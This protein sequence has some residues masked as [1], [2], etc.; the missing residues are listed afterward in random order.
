MNNLMGNGIDLL[1]I[2]FFAGC[3]LTAAIG[4]PLL[5]FR[6]IS[7]CKSWRFNRRLFL[8]FV[9][10][11]L[12]WAAQFFI[13]RPPFDGVYVFRDYTIIFSVWTILAVLYFYFR[14]FVPLSIHCTGIV[15]LGL[16][17]F[18]CFIF[19]TVTFEQVRWYMLIGCFFGSIISFPMWLLVLSGFMNDPGQ[20]SLKNTVERQI[21]EDDSQNSI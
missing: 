8:M 14:Y 9:I 2:L 12:V 1:M 15:F 10:M 13:S 20:E 18:V 21:K 3:L 5:I 11:S 19:G 6:G 4:L 17:P 16:L 7:R